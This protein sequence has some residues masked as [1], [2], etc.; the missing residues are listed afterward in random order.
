MLLAGS[1]TIYQVLPQA[2][3]KKKQKLQVRTLPCALLC[4]CAASA[5]PASQRCNLVLRSHLVI[6]TA[7][8]TVT[9]SA[10]L[11]V[12]A[13]GRH[14]LPVTVHRGTGH[15]WHQAQCVCLRRR[16]VRRGECQGV[17][18]DSSHRHAVMA[19]CSIECFP[20]ECSPIACQPDSWHFVCIGPGR[21]GELLQLV[22]FRHQSRQP[23]GSHSHRVRPGQR[24]LQT[25]SRTKTYRIVQSG[26]S[27]AVQPIA[28]NRCV[29]T[30]KFACDTVRCAKCRTTSRG[31][32]ALAFQRP[33]WC[34]P[35]GCL[36][37][38]PKIT[39]TWRPLR[40]AAA[41]PLPHARTGRHLSSL[42]NFMLK[43]WRATPAH[44]SR[45]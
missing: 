11:S 6:S 33:P 41:Q 28:G 22:L 23:A 36:W 20:I 21:K 13:A 45:L 7:D 26:A 2:G 37:R 8:E 43:R 1:T 32:S 17:S 25:L 15:G 9:Q 39:R 18:H 4:T 3:E 12:M 30:R 27:S 34:W 16:S 19:L 38:A 44:V 14:L 42:K 5:V 40:G 31:Q 29:C 24:P 35:S 10:N